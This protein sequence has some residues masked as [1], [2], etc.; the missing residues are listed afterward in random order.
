MENGNDKIIKLLATVKDN[1]D[2]GQFIPIQKSAIKALNSNVNKQMATIYQRRLKYLVKSLKSLNLDVSMPKAGFYLYV[3]VPEYINSRKIN[4][5]SE[6]AIFLLE[7]EQ[8]FVIPYDNAGKF[9]RI[10]VAFVAKNK[11]EEHQII[12][13]LKSRLLKYLF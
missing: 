12:N 8:I 1:C 10:S 2:S 5:A 11:Q 3:K 13:E 4:S 7:Q 9:I 6:F